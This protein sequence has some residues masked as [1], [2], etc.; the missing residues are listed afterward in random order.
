MPNDILTLILIHEALCGLLLWTVFCRSVQCSRKVLLD[1]RLAFWLLGLIACLGLVAPLVWG[2]IPDLFSI[3][4]VAAIT[5][6]QFV[7][8]QHWAQGVPKHFM[9]GGDRACDC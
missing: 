2:F 8:A 7:T 1:V 9:K 5:V 3:A 6:V 4:L